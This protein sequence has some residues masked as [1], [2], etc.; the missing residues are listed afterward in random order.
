MERRK[1]MINK[2][3]ILE[4][5][6]TY[7]LIIIL[8]LL[9]FLSLIRLV[10][11][12]THAFYNSQSD[13]IPIFKAK[14]GDFTGEGESVKEGPI[15]KNTDVNIIFY[16]QMPD[17]PDKYMVSKYLPVNGYKVN[18]KV[19]NCYPATGGDATYNNY[20]IDSEGNLNITYT[21]TKPTQVVCRIY[22]D[23]DKLSDVIIYA[24]LEDASGDKK[25]NNKTYKLVNQ[26]ESNYTL[27]AHECKNKRATFSYDENGFNITSSGPDTCY[28]YFS[29]S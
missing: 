8:S 17:N 22:Y 7:M 10:L 6:K 2:I 28:A 5:K 12:E 21:E 13:S 14:I 3:K 11:K 20:N 25:Y 1:E 23:R 19:S 27:V 29:E 24:Y 9:L 26:V 18:E 15:D 4:N 16:T